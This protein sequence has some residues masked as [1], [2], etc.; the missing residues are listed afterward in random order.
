VLELWTTLSDADS[1]TLTA[2]DELGSVMPQV[3]KAVLHQIVSCELGVAELPADTDNRPP[4]ISLSRRKAASKG[5]FGP[6]MPS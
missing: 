4:C 6:V 2:R 5:A 1:S 3:S